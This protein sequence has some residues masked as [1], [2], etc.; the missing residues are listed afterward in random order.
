MPCSTERSRPLAATP[1]SSAVASA[2]DLRLPVLASRDLLGPANQVLI[3]HEGMVYS[4][5]A[6]RNGKLILTK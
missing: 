1:R 6:T 3:E 2:A 4:L 5:R